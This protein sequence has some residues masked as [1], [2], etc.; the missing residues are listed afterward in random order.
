MGINDS[1]RP[2]HFSPLHFIE[3]TGLRSPELPA[4]AALDELPPRLASAVYPV[5]R[6]VLLFA[7]QEPDAERMDTA[8]MR[9]WEEEL[10][11]TASGDLLL[12]PLAVIVGLLAEAWPVDRATLSYACLAAADAAHQ[13]NA[14][15]TGL[16]FTEAAALCR[17]ENA[18]LAY[19]AGRSFKNGGRRRE[20]ERWLTR[21]A[22]IAHGSGDGLAYALCH[23]SLGMLHWE[24][25]ANPKSRTH[26]RRALRSARQHRH[27]NVQAIVLHNLFLVGVTSG[28]LEG[29]EEYARRAFD[30][31]GPHNPRLPA[32]AYDVAYYWLTRGHAARALP[33]FQALGERFEDPEQRIQV[34]AAQARAAGAAGEVNAFDRAWAD[35][36]ELLASASIRATRAAALVDLG[37]GAAHSERWPAAEAPFLEAMASA[38]A[39]GQCDMLIRAEE[40]LRA[41]RSGMNPDTLPRPAQISRYQPAAEGLARACL[42]ALSVFREAVHCPAGEDAFM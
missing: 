6:L 28:D 39:L 22:R 10:L 30:L 25:G 40:C 38:E 15:G 26:L 9:V 33:I 12:L 1:V 14:E 20:A 18:R 17:P 24:C 16:A 32:L 3:R 5:L 34:L 11:R 29:V 31:Y 27:R 21:A 41:V 4:R 2:A 8:G 7:D 42:H 36:H 23:N 13:L 19:L 37:L 35:A